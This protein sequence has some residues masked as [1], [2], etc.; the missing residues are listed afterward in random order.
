M[1]K[2]APEDPQTHSADNAERLRKHLPEVS[3]GERVDLPIKR[4][5]LGQ[6]RRATRNHAWP[7]RKEAD[8]LR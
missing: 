7:K 5:Y 3:T 1:K 8:W 4:G 2:I 6:M